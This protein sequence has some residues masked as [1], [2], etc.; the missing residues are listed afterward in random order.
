MSDPKRPRPSAPTTSIGHAAAGRDSTIHIG[1]ST[2]TNYFGA[3]DVPAPA[4]PPGLMVVGRIPRRAPHFVDRAQ[5][6]QLRETLARC[7]V[8]VVCGMRGAGKTQVAAAY[9]REVID[10][11]EPGLVAWV[12]AESSETLHTGLAEIAERVGVADPDGDSTVSA[13]RLRDHLSERRE[14]ALIVLDN[15]TDPDLLDTVLPS[16]G[17][18]RV[19]VTSTDRTFDQFGALID[20]GEGFDRPESVRF[21]EDATGLADEP[22]ADLVADDLGDLPLALSAA[23]ATIN[24]RG[25]DY[26]RYR[27][28]LAEGSLAA[29]LPRRRG[30]DHPLAV[31]QA[32]LLA[33]QTIE[34]TLADPE[35]D[36]V[37]R[38]LL[39]VMSMLAPDGVERAMLPDRDGRLD[40]ALQRCVEGSLLS[41]SVTGNA[42]VMHRLLARVLR[43]RTP[44]PNAPAAD[45]T[46]V[47]EA[48][49]FDE[50]EA[51]ARRTEGS[52]LIDHIEAL[53]HAIDTTTD[54]N[55]DLAATVL[56]LR[57][58]ATRQLIKSA[59]TTRSIT[60]ALHT[61]TDRQRISGPDHPT[62]L[63]SRNN[64]A[65]AYESAGRLAEAITL[66]EQNL[67]ESE[68]VLGPDHP[69]TLTSRNNLA[70]AYE[71]AGRLAEA[72]TLY[73]QTLTESERVLGPDHPTTLTSRNNLA[74]TY[75]SAGRLAEAITLYEQTLTDS[76]RLLGPDHP[77]TLT[78]RNNLAYTY[79]SAGRLA[80]AITLYE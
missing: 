41:R 40:E 18:T 80:E 8:A 1:N 12:N 38:W 50:S 4:V 76:D 11:G 23:A 78:S 70:S 57:S 26:P 36:A 46:A 10:A 53:W 16:G 42:I 67:T 45:A 79:E 31:D 52:R 73:E 74:Y 7:A 30:S 64:L 68:R 39:G 48:L 66:H 49:A 28:L 15:A 63:T 24:G 34:T 20:T 37:V 61:L 58:W 25:L 43:E 47:L 13:R 14:P 71:S 2:T 65:S 27:Q 6:R 22:G 44:Q 32:L 51:F 5:V 17:V 9:A 56:D 55:P 54:P 75:E 72:I 62:T 60:Q 29:A 19:V 77:T 3:A 33:V 35:L 21:L 69:T 59:D